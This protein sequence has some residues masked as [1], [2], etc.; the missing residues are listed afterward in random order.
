[1]AATATL[2][3]HPKLADCWL[4]Q[5][6]GLYYVVSPAWGDGFIVEY[7]WITEPVRN[8]FC[9]GDT[10]ATLDDASAAIDA[11][12]NERAAALRGEA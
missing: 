2:R 9:I 11:F 5:R 12:A 4:H 1:M 10:Y 7:G 3:E 6:D 8:P